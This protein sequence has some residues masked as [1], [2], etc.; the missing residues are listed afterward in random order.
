MTAEAVTGWRVILYGRNFKVLGSVS[1][2]RGEHRQFIRKRLLGL[3]ELIG[4]IAD[5]SCA[6]YQAVELV[7]NR[8]ARYSKYD[9]A[10]VQG[11][12]SAFPS[13]DVDGLFVQHTPTETVE[14][15]AYCLVVLD[16]ILR[17]FE[18]ALDNHENEVWIRIST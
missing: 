13:D 2:N 8:E 11:F 1:I 10:I 6:E 15:R 4:D 17:G 3:I 14:G 9:Q 16:A 7:G 5:S 18:S 12:R